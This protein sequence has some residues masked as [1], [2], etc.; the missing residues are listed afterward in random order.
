[1]VVSGYI[2]HHVSIGC[3]KA[4]DPSARDA[5]AYL[6]D[7]IEQTPETSH[8]SLEEWGA[9]APGLRMY[10]ARGL[11]AAGLLETIITSARN[12]L[13]ILLGWEKPPFNFRTVK[14][15][16][17]GGNPVSA[18]YS[19]EGNMLA[20]LTETPE[21]NILIRDGKDLPGN[22]LIPLNVPGANA[23]AFDPNAFLVSGFNGRF[24]QRCWKT[25]GPA[26]MPT[27]RMPS[28]PITAIAGGPEQNDVVFGTPDAIIKYNFAT[29][30]SRILLHAAPSVTALTYLS[31][32]HFLAVAGKSEIF[33]LDPY[34]NTAKISPRKILDGDESITAI[35]SLPANYYLFVGTNRGRVLAVHTES[36]APYATAQIGKP[37]DHR[38]I[39]AIWVS[40]EWKQMRIVSS[41]ENEKN[42]YRVDL[43]KVA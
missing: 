13:P 19:R 26:D 20:L 34:V 42:R 1:M 21:T 31:S 15:L 11:A 12:Q 35:G 27:D 23:L 43:C 24:L 18:A 2:R 6:K 17:V 32:K 10:H 30:S 3:S 5:Y 7:R 38:R 29:R 36:L 37:E 41:S 33:L 39:H 40:E 9:F 4:P 25:N 28:E 14:S 8:F 22:Y 16:P